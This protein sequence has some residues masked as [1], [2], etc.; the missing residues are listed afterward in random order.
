MSP[1]FL[2]SFPVYFRPRFAIL[3]PFK[4]HTP[5]TTT[6]RLTISVSFFFRLTRVR[7]RENNRFFFF[8][9]VY[10]LF[11]E[12]TTFCGISFIS[13]TNTVSANA[14]PGPTTR[15]GFRVSNPVTPKKHTATSGQP[16]EIGARKIVLVLKILCTIMLFTN[17]SKRSR[18]VFNRSLLCVPSSTR[19]VPSSTR[20]HTGSCGHIGRPLRSAANTVVH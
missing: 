19:C 20:G 6:R 15:G 14:Q 11:R 17:R 18:T 10:F 4:G 7:Y 5:V 12:N 1:R 13:D 9:V 16:P 3:S 8:F 2:A